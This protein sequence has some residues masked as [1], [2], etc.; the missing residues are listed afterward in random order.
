MESGIAGATPKTTALPSRVNCTVPRSLTSQSPT[1]A[2]VTSAA[3]AVPPR[4]ARSGA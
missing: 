1:C 3:A 2:G 4:A